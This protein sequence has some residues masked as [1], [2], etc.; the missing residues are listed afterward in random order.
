MGA[1]QCAASAS[2]SSGSSSSS[3]S[4]SS[5]SSSSASSSSS[6]TPEES[7]SPQGDH[8]AKQT[9]QLATSV[10]IN[11][12]PIPTNTMAER[13]APVTQAKAETES[14]SDT[15]E[16]TD[17]HAQEDRTE[18]ESSEDSRLGRAKKRLRMRVLKSTSAMMAD[19]DGSGDYAEYEQIDEKGSED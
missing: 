8:V 17:Q 7:S 18:D 1:G 3:T 19:S 9:R 16:Q 11:S 5:A 4:S 12:I 13:L 10:G 6:A 15:P 2:S 14:S